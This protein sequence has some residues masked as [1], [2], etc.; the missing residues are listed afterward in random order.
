M[1]FDHDLVGIGERGVNRAMGIDSGDGN[2]G[3]LFAHFGLRHKRVGEFGQPN[4]ARGE[5][6][7][8]RKLQTEFGFKAGLGAVV[9][10]HRVLRAPERD[11]H[12]AHLIGLQIFAVHNVEH[13]VNAAVSRVAHRVALDRQARVENAQALAQIARAGLQIGLALRR[14]RMQETGAVLE[15]V[16]G[17]GEAQL[18]QLHRLNAGRSGA[19]GVQRFGHGAEVGDQPARHAAGQAQRP[20]AQLHRQFVQMRHRSGSGDGTEHTS[21]MPAFQMVLAAVAAVQLGP[22]FIADDIGA[23]QIGTG[24]TQHMP[25]SQDGRRDDRARVAGQRHVVVVER[26]RGGA[27]DA[28]GLRTRQQN[29][30]E[31][32]RCCRAATAA[33]EVGVVLEQNAHHRLGAAGEHGG[34]GVGDAGFGNREGFAAAGI[35][36]WVDGKLGELKRESGHGDILM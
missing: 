14:D 16:R 22:H 12:L 27:V 24:A 28:G 6:R 18:G 3:E 36:A 4:A 9:A 19:A 17:R 2:L 7:G 26:V 11:R 30:F 10:Q 13:G 34:G 21:R 15:H 33:G 5:R 32:H 29:F 35:E 8:H 20:H 1:G 23:Q 31:R 25:L